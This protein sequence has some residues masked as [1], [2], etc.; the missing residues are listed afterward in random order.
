MSTCHH[1]RNEYDASPCGHCARE[2]ELQAENERL[3]QTIEQMR[4]NT[5]FVEASHVKQITD[6]LRAKIAEVSDERDELKVLAQLTLSE[7]IGLLQTLKEK[8]R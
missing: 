7:V 3:K 8:F 4:P 2:N 1:G 6:E 5:S